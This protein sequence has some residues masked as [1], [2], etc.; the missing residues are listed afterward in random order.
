MKTVP[1]REASCLRAR[2]EGVGVEVGEGLGGRD[3]SPGDRVL[4]VA[5]EP[6]LRLMGEDWEKMGPGLTFPCRWSKYR[7]EYIF[8]TCVTE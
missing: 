8:D 1:F 5:G 3:L 6:T 7:T 4:E 2:Y